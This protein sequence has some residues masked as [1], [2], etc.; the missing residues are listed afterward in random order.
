MAENLFLRFTVLDSPELNRDD[1]DASEQEQDLQNQHALSIEWMV[2]DE[3]SGIARFRGED[4]LESFAASLSDLQW[5]GATYVML[6]GE[7][8]LLTQADIPSK[9]TRQIQQALPFM[10][11][12]NLAV[13]IDDCHF[14]IGD[15]DT[16][17]LL[18]V[19]V[20]SL[21]RMDYWLEV[22]ASLNLKADLLTVDILSLPWQEGCVIL[23]DGKRSLFRT[24][25]S[26][27]IAIE[28]NLT[29][30]AA[31]MLE[32]KSALSFLV[33]ESQKDAWALTI[34]QIGAEQESKLDIVDIEYPPFEFLCRHFNQSAINLLQGKYKRK[35]DKKSGT[36]TWRSV[37]VLAACAFA[38]H[39]ALLVGQGIFL[40]IKAKQAEADAI[41]LYA[42]VFPKDRNV[43]D[44]RR[45]WRSHLGQKGE[46]TGDFLS[47]FSET[48][49]QLPGSKLILNS[50]N[51]N[52]G[53]GSLVL[54]LEAPKSEQL[55]QYSQV[56]SKLGLNAEIGTIN[57][58][59]S[60]VK[61]SIKVRITGGS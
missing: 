52:E 28:S 2:L 55:I 29:S 38:F 23:A 37:V 31:N 22:L 11:E 26:S 36:N 6:P 46:E 5:D 20:I 25:T 16:N 24:A 43:R 50:L 47:L 59:D 15:R 54:Q 8:V 4:E 9:Q 18:N 7:E 19:A 49:K 39:I 45:R 12:E 57:Q 27:G 44:L 61:G 35:Q 13:D 17:N 10:V 3:V 51:Y 53:R 58:G 14:A 34:S 48:L 30:L 60:S 56:L 33:H 42:S 41:S 32:D 1:A 40:D 21:S